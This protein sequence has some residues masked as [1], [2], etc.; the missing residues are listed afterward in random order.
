M[1]LQLLQLLAAIWSP[2][3]AQEHKYDG[4]G[5]ENIQQ[6]YCLAVAGL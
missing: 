4:P 3:A 1:G 2:G 5:A 6:P